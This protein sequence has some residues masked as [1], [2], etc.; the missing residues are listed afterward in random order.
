MFSRLIERIFVAIVLASLVACA[1][2]PKQK[3]L[4]S[5]GSR[6]LKTVHRN[7]ILIS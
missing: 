7:Q 2:G 5:D 1:S 4:I 3:S 6:L